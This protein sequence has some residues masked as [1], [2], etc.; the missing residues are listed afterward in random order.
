MN[1]AYNS[2]SS[3]N[4]ANQCPRRYYYKYKEKLPEKRNICLIGGDVVHQAIKKKADNPGED[5]EKLFQETW[6]EAVPEM[7]ELGLSREEIERY[8]EDY[9]RMALNWVKDFNPSVRTSCEVKLKS[10]KLKAVG[11]GKTNIAFILINQLMK[12]QVPFLI[13]DWKKNYRSLMAV[14]KDV[15]VF[16]PGTSTSPFYFNP[17]IPPPNVPPQVWK[18]FIASAIGYSYFIGEGALTILEKGMDEVYREYGVYDGTAQDYPT[19]HDVAKKVFSKGQKRGREMLWQ[20][21]CARTLYALTSSTIAESINVARNPVPIEAALKNNVVIEL[22][23]L[24][25]SNK[26]FFTQALLLWIYFH[27]LNQPKAEVLKH[28]IIIEEAQNLLLAGKEEMKSG[29]IMPKIIREFRELG[30]GL[31]FIAQEVSKMNTTALQNT[32]T[33]I[34]LNQRYRKD[35]ET[36]AS[37]MSIKFQEWDCL[38]KLP[39][40][41]AM[42]NMKGSHPESFLVQF[43]FSKIKADVSDEM[44]EREMQNS[45]FSLKRVVQAPR[46]SFQVFSNEAYS[47]PSKAKKPQMDEE[48]ALLLDIYEN[49]QRSVSE[50]YRQLGLNYRVGNDHKKDLIRKGCLKE[51]VVTTG[52]A[53]IKILTLTEEGLK[54]LKAIGLP[55]RGHK[56]GGGEHEYWKSRMVDKLQQDGYRTKEEVPIPNRK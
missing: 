17:L 22:D 7:L 56:G 44:I 48:D 35:I 2:P 43:P 18:E 3:I 26:V 55:A 9:R 20:Q 33:L 54:R 10:D 15:M 14:K 25:P 27:R 5:M 8:R 34:A 23:Y 30:T 24:S 39:I 37:S 21:S 31:T 29:N 50:H 47:P 41:S 45:L 6:Q 16:T 11:S 36:L 12:N 28:M 1:H 46:R 32:H 53:R 4:T 49:P 40:G 42:V 38:G 51:E 19:F 13:F 52:K